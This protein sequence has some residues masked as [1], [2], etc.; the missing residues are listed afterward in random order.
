MHGNIARS[1]VTCF[2]QL[3]KRV[4]IITKMLAPENYN[5]KLKQKCQHSKGLEIMSHDFGLQTILQND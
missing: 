4:E 2:Q 1:S 3:L 5:R